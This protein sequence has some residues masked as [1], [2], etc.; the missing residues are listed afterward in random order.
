VIGMA[1]WNKM[2]MD[3]ILAKDEDDFQKKKDRYVKEA[4][5]TVIV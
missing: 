4:I 1:D 3:C 5:K 2:M